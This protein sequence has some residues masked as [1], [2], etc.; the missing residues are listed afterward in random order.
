[1]LI[2]TLQ[3][4]IPRTD[5]VSAAVYQTL[6]VFYS[7]GKVSQLLPII[8]VTKIKTAKNCRFV[9]YQFD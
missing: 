7:F 1:M 8:D 5:F 9:L 4:F 2:T 3:R 6:D